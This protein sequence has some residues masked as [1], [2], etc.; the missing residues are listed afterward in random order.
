M[1]RTDREITNIVEIESILN[2]SMVCRSGLA[3]GSEP[4]II[5]VCFGN[6]PGIIYLHS[7]LSGKKLT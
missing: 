6:L 1:K 7:F 3:D 2:A 4:H 5:P